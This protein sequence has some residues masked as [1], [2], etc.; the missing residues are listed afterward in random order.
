MIP[1]TQAAKLHHQQVILFLVSALNFT[2][3]YVH[4]ITGCIIDDVYLYHC[5]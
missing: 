5:V 3:H 1:R 2:Q 4:H